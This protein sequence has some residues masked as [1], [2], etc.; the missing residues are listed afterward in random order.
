M[1]ITNPRILRS[2]F[3]RLWGGG[4]NGNSSKNGGSSKEKA[5]TPEPVLEAKELLSTPGRNIRPFLTFCTWDLKNA[6]QYIKF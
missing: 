1:L 5:R 3:S 2:S 4:G 6:Y